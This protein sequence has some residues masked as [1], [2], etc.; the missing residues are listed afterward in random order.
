VERSCNLIRTAQKRSR[1]DKDSSSSDRQLELPI[2]GKNGDTHPG[3]NGSAHD[4]PL[5]EQ[6]G[7]SENGLHDDEAADDEPIP[8][9]SGDGARHT[10]RRRATAQSMAAAQ[11]DISVSEF[12]AK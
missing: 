6:N 2:E 12:F 3:A 11:R 8:A 4:E 10:R 5:H 7:A 1:K 9:T